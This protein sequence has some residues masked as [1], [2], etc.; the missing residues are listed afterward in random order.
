MSER[1]GF[2]C[3]KGH[4]HTQFKGEIDYGACGSKEVAEIT[5]TVTDRE[6]L[7]P[8]Y[9]NLKSSADV[10]KEIQEIIR[11]WDAWREEKRWEDEG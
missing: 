5:V 4:G 8:E 2:I 10:A 6:D 11:E 7:Y 3:G 9:R 1:I